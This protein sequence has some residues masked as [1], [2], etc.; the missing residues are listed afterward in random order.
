[1][2]QVQHALLEF[3][4]DGSL[5]ADLYSLRDRASAAFSK[6]TFVAE[7]FSGDQV[8]V[9]ELSVSYRVRRR[10]KANGKNL[11]FSAAGAPY[12]RWFVVDSQS[13]TVLQRDVDLEALARELGALKP[14]ESVHRQD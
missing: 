3:P 2:V 4:D 11:R 1:L 5:A 14:T 6:G 8:N 7:T 12:G 10:L 13:N 9:P